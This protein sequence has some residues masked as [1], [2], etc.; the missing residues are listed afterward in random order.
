MSH[1]D[2]EEYLADLAYAVREADSFRI[3]T[4]EA[5]TARNMLEQYVEERMDPETKR[6]LEAAKISMK[7]EDLQSVLKH[8]QSQGYITKLVRACAEILEQLDDADAAIAAAKRE[9]SE[10]FLEKALA[11][12]DVFNYNVE[13]VQEARLLLKNIR[14]ARAGCT[15]ALVPPFKIDWLKKVRERPRHT[16]TRSKPTLITRAERSAH[17]HVH[18]GGS[19]AGDRALALSTKGIVICVCVPCC[20]LCHFIVATAGRGI[21]CQ[22]KLHAVP[23]IRGVQFLATKHQWGDQHAGNRAG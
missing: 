1:A 4:K 19:R 3:K 8:C 9:M 10:E 5:E 15:K 18:A 12:C 17:T 22:F 7:K 21:L 2:K 23:R 13:S 16:L 11:M 14:K 6:R 20:G